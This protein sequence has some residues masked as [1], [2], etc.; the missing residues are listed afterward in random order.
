MRNTAFTAKITKSDQ[1]RAYLAY[2]ATTA[3][4]TKNNKTHKKRASLAYTAKNALTTPNP[5]P[6]PNPTPSEHFVL[7][8]G[9][10]KTAET[11]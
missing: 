2:T 6:N 7:I 1:K 5:N 3:K 9:N 11:T 4:V 10:T 8:A